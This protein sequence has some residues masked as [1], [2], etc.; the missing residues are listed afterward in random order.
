MN[1]PESPQNLHR[2]RDFL[3][4]FILTL[5]HA[6]I[7]FFLSNGLATPLFPILGILIPLLG[8][9]WA[10]TKHRRHI[11]FGILTAIIAI[12]LLLIGTCFAVFSI[13]GFS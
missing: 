10:F 2:G 8:I 3:L 5:C 9:F 13:S 1:T 6:I 12:P 7:I 11:A 4:G